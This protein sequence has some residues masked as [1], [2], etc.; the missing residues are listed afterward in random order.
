LDGVVELKVGDGVL[1]AEILDTGAVGE[2]EI[3]V[4]DTDTTNDGEAE[5]EGEIVV[6]LTVYTGQASWDHI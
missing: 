2:G 3:V 6:L 5:I 1:E 4:L